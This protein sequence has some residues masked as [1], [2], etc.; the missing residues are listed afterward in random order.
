[1][2]KTIWRLCK[3]FKISKLAFQTVEDEPRE[4]VR[5]GIVGVWQ[6][7]F[8]V[9]VPS[10]VTTCALDGSCEP[11]LPFSHK[12]PSGHSFLAPLHPV[13]VDRIYYLNQNL[14]ICSGLCQF[15]PSASTDGLPEADLDKPGCGWPACVAGATLV[16]RRPVT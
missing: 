10:S 15:S 14:Y 16:Q 4:V 9:L 6:F 1:S 12:T 11:M 8:I 7:R 3:S 5:L 13:W 2:A